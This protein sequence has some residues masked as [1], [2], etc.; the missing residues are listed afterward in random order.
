M[1]KPKREKRRASSRRRRPVNPGSRDYPV[2]GEATLATGTGQ[3][4]LH[5]LPLDSTIEPESLLSKAIITKGRLFIS[6]RTEDSAG[7]SGRLSDRLK[8]RFGSESIFMDVDRIGPGTD[9]PKVLQKAVASCNVLLA[10]IGPSWTSATDK[11]GKRRLDDHSDWVRMEVRTALKRKIRVIPVL[12]GGSRMP[13]TELLPNDLHVL[14]E[15]QGHELRDKRWT[16]DMEKLMESFS[17]DMESRVVR[18]DPLRK[19][20][21]TFDIRLAL[22]SI[23]ELDSRAYV[24]GIYHNVAPS[25]PANAI[26]E[27]MGGAINTFTTRRMF[28][29]NA[30]EVFVMPTGRHPLQADFIIFVGLGDFDQFSDTVL[31]VCAE[32]IVRTCVEAR[33]E[34]FGTVLLGGRSGQ[35]IHLLL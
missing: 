11:T 22:G 3:S 21:H 34:E 29:G 15:L 25:G 33:V 8:E 12:V 35:D 17:S 32:N 30:G 1:A 23:T 31:Q 16:D 14:A 27:R 28:S 4:S 18:S 24:L 13:T 26:D 2:A 6:Y 5:E 7:W 10:V 19:K 9:F 20:Q